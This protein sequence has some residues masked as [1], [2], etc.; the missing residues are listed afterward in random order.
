MSV[1]RMVFYQ[2]FKFICGKNEVKGNKE[3]NNSMNSIKIPPTQ[4]SQTQSFSNKYKSVKSVQ[5]LKD[6]Y[7]EKIIPN[8]NITDK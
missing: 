7:I 1:K 2:M 5:S 3:Q 4:T 6:K 8:N